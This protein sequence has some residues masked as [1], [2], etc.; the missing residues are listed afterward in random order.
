MLRLLKIAHPCKIQ[1]RQS[2]RRI[3]TTA[4]DDVKNVLQSFQSLCEAYLFKPI[5]IGELR[6]YLRTFQLHRNRVRQ[7]SAKKVELQWIHVRVK[8]WR[9]PA[10]Y[11]VFCPPAVSSCCSSAFCQLELVLYSFSDLARASVFLPRSF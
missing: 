9:A 8:R 5:D 7:V 2:C 1:E 10:A 6:D 11:L 3:I 4:L